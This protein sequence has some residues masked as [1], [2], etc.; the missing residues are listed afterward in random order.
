MKPTHIPWTLLF[1][2]VGG[3]L[4]VIMMGLVLV[5]VVRCQWNKKINIHQVNEGIAG[6]L[7]TRDQE[8]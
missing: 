3:G 8:I 4:L 6:S 2:G 1:V 7:K 5:G